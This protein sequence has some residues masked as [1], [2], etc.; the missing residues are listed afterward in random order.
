[1]IDVG[2]CLTDPVTGATGRAFNALLAAPPPGISPTAF[3]AGSPGR[4]VLA[5]LLQAVVKGV[6]DELVASGEVTVTGMANLGTGA[7][8]GTGTIG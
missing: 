3:E 8:T 6:M 5:S 2:Q 1:M 4:A 7:V